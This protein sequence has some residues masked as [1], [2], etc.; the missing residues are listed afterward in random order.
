MEEMDPQRVEMARASAVDYEKV[1]GE[2]LGGLAT[3][4]RLSGDLENA[5]TTFTRI[6][7]G[8]PRVPWQVRCF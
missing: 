6:A 8:P 1:L 7:R 4:Y 5:R 3:A 2:L